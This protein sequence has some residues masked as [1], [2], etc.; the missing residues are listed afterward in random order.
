MAGNS[1]RQGAI[2]KPGS[3]KGA[4][5]GSGGQSR[6]SLE[7]NDH[8]DRSYQEASC[9]GG[10]RILLHISPTKRTCQALREHDPDTRIQ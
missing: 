7:G 10:A 8:P 4:V 9:R 1:K 2:R 5:K 6:K 3:K